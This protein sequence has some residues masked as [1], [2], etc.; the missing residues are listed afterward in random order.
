[1]L[2]KSC[3]ESWEWGRISLHAIINE[4]NWGGHPLYPQKSPF[5]SSPT[6]SVLNKLFYS[7]VFVKCY[8]GSF[9]LLLLN[10]CIV[11]W[12]FSCGITPPIAHVIIPKLPW[13]AVIPHMIVTWPILLLLRILLL[14]LEAMTP[15]QSLS[16]W[17]SPQTQVGKP[18]W[19]VLLEELEKW[20][21]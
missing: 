2:L 3:L 14:D 8:F 1:M 11:S 16:P 4:T 13:H 10:N 18:S 6:V 12:A 21:V 17:S 7:R 5:G 19:Y 9:L 20:S 15:L